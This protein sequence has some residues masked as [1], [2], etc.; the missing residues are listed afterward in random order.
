M[1]MDEMK[2]MTQ[3][4]DASQ[5]AAIA[6]EK[7]ASTAE[8]TLKEALENLRELE[9][10]LSVFHVEVEN[11]DHRINEIES[12]SSTAIAQANEEVE[13]LKQK[14]A[15]AELSASD[16]KANIDRRVADVQAKA[17]FEKTELL[18]SLETLKADDK[19]SASATDENLKTITS[20]ESKMSELTTEIEKLQNSKLREETSTA[21]Q[22][23]ALHEANQ[24]IAELQATIDATAKSLPANTT[25]TVVDH[26]EQADEKENEGTDKFVESL[27]TSAS[28]KNKK[29]KK[30]KGKGGASSGTV[31]IVEEAASKVSETVPEPT[32]AQDRTL[33]GVQAYETKI[34]NLQKEVGALKSEREASMEEVENL[35]DQVRSIGQDLVEAKDEIKM[36]SGQLSSSSDSGKSFAELEAAHAE[37]VHKH[38]ALEHAHEE[39]M[40]AKKLLDERLETL[41]NEHETTVAQLSQLTADNQQSVADLT[42]ALEEKEKLLTQVKALAAEKEDALQQVKAAVANKEKS[43]SQIELKMQDLS[44]DLKAT[45]QV[46]QA[47]FKELSDKNEA[48]QRLSNDLQTVRTEGASLREERL[49]LTTKLEEL[50]RVEKSE[51]QL[52]VDVSKFRAAILERDSDLQKTRQQLREAQTGKARADE[53]IVTLSQHITR[54]EAELHGSSEAVDKLSREKG[55]LVQDLESLRARLSN[56]SASNS[57]IKAQLEAMKEENQIAKAE[58]ES[59]KTM[60]DTFR[61]QA[62]E[63]AMQ[64]KEAR[65]R[66]GALEE[67]LAEAHRLLIE[68]GREATTIR[69]LLS[70]AEAKQENSVRELKEQINVLTEERDRAESESVAISRRKRRELEDLKIKDREL[71]RKLGMVEEERSKLTAELNDLRAARERAEEKAKLAQS[72]MEETRKIFA[73]LRSSLVGFFLFCATNR[74]ATNSESFRRRLKPNYRKQRLTG[75]H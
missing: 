26:D 67:E 75:K 27:A 60:M 15:A 28:S 56:Y 33:T 29:K 62:S 13:G 11:R 2:R 51:R 18:A 70:E 52:K 41:I 1:L 3:E 30:K 19:R 36:L 71:E 6:A 61:E 8:Q 59:A 44:N 55:Q 10:E 72:E 20:Y 7:K 53:R 65:D 22:N 42:A 31:P 38:G 17:D 64:S 63:M 50:R 25:E 45:E 14:L 21:A 47:R 16:I 54:T 48:L 35:R 23:I 34:V 49:T 58:T 66:Y 39:L 40:N 9:S 43:I 4:K 24:K 73:D 37:L 5:Q 12:S 46:A 68:R 57:K 32:V 69:R 74:N